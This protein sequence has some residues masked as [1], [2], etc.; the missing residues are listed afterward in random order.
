MMGNQP[1]GS[2]ADPGKVADAQLAGITERGGDH[3]AGGIGQSPG[4]LTRD[5]QVRLRRP[6][7]P[8]SLGDREVKA[9]QV[10][11]IRITHRNILMV[12]CM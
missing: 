1:V 8:E 12:I 9:Q 11:G 4:P 6:L 3:Q 10:T 5:G 2:F 7:Q